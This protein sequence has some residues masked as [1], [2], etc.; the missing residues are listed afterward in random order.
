MNNKK[1]NAEKLYNAL[2][3][4]K[5]NE[6]GRDLRQE[7]DVLS[8]FVKHG[9][10]QIKIPPMFKTKHEKELI[11]CGRGALSKLAMAHKQGL[12]VCHHPFGKNRYP[13]FLLIIYG[14]ILEFEIKSASSETPIFSQGDKVVDPTRRDSI[15]LFTHKTEGTSMLLAEDLMTPE[16]YLLILKQK[17]ERALLQARHDKEFNK[18]CKGRGEKVYHRT[19]LA[20]RGG[21][22]ITNHI[23][24]ARTHNLSQKV[25]YVLK[26]YEFNCTL[27]SV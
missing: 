10:E 4:I 2:I 6:Q 26:T 22:E 3:K 21:T 16:N 23:S 5:Y 18:V 1:L 15:Y 7:Q 19:N 9:F 11:D 8:T 12:Y 14:R 25:L 27:S 24:R 17:Q 20:P 13:D